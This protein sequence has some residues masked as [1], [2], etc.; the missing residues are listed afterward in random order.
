[1]KDRARRLSKTRAMSQVVVRGRRIA[2]HLE[3]GSG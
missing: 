3:D 2:D 1:M